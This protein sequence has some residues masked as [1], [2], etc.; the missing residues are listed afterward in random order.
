MEEKILMKSERKNYWIVIGILCAI[1]IFLIIYS[2]YC[3]DTYKFDRRSYQFLSYGDQRTATDYFSYLSSGVLFGGGS[4][5]EAAM[6]ISAIFIVIVAL[7][8]IWWLSKTEMVVTDKR[9]YGKVAFGKRVDLPLD[10]ISAVAMG[11]LGAISV[12]TSSGKVSFLIMKN[13]KELHACI[14]ELLV[15]R[16]NNTTTNS[17]TTDLRKFKSLLDDGLIT[18]EEYDAKKKQILGL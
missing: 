5:E 18:Q 11:P 3:F 7:I 1:S 15:S 9:V 14:N 2:I 4:T 16:Q 10:S 13:N 17:D 12:G 8:I 6:L